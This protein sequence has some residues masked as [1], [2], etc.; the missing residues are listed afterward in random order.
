MDRDAKSFEKWAEERFQTKNSQA[1]Q[2][3]VDNDM[4]SKYEANAVPCLLNKVAKLTISQIQG[5]LYSGDLLSKF[6]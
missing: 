1:R 2:I 3:N 6:K 4:N 5:M